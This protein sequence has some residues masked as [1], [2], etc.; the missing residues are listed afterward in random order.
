M[1]KFALL[2]LLSL[3]LTAQAAETYELDPYH[4]NILRHANHFGFS[5][6][7]GKFVNTQGT[8]VLDEKNPEKSKLDVTI[9][10]G[11]I[12]TG[13]AKFD[14]H[15]RG[16][17]FLNAEKFPTAT[18][19]SKKIDLE[20]KDRAKVLGDFTLLGVTKPVT[21]DVKLNKLGE[22][23]M[24]KVKTAGF[25]ASTTIKRSEFGMGFG[26]PNVSDEIRIDIETEANL[27]Q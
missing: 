23:P 8:L 27:K 26:I 10:P 7:D 21:L 22:N 9:K 11:S 12:T 14:E 5:N 19:V 16:K 3:P 15:I 4:T 24:T 2:I 17:D 25:T 18:F 13:S 1:K 20:G 6:P